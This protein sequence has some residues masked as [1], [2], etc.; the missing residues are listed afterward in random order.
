MPLV[1]AK[2]FSEDR[3]IPY[4][5]TQRRKARLNKIHRPADFADR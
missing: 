5:A 3:L 1:L 2:G 4:W